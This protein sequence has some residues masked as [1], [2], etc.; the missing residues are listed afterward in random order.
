MDKTRSPPQ[1]N[2]DNNTA[3]PCAHSPA[4][5]RDNSHSYCVLLHPQRRLRHQGFAAR[6]VS[7]NFAFHEE[8]FV[9]EVHLDSDHDGMNRVQGRW[10]VCNNTM[11]FDRYDEIQNDDKNAEINYK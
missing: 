1:M 4:A 3:D 2:I 6:P 10:N 11:L 9:G 7:T 5:R 8:S